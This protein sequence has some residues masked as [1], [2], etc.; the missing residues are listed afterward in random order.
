M[1]KS[2]E[3]IQQSIR[4]E[5]ADAEMKAWEALS[6]YKFW[7]FG[8][9]AA[10]WVQMN[11]L[12]GGGAGNPWKNLVATARAEVDKRAGQLSMDVPDDIRKVPNP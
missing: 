12:I 6:G 10:R 2:T 3:S 5:L 1:T 7:M 4:N 8:Y 9:H 11:R